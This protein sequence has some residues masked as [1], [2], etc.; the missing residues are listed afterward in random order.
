MTIR[1]LISI[2]LS[3]TF[4][5][6]LPCAAQWESPTT[7]VAPAPTPAPETEPAAVIT[8]PTDEPAAVISPPTDEPQAVI[9]PPT[10]NPPGVD[11][12]PGAISPPGTPSQTVTGGVKSSPPNASKGGAKAP[13]GPISKSISFIGSAYNGIKMVD[14]G[15][16]DR[17]SIIGKTVDWTFEGAVDTL[18]FTTL[19]T[20]KNAARGVFFVGDQAA[21]G[22]GGV[23]K[24]KKAKTPKT[25][26]L[27]KPPGDAPEKP[28][29]GEPAA[30][31]KLESHPTNTGAP[32]V[33][34]PADMP[35][36]DPS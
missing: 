21:K 24:T 5:L 6:P 20:G 25:K 23:V 27:Q 14:R 29:D 17:L 18:I 22:V 2:L 11:T 4:V 31:P 3:G 9:S 10:D 34:R 7:P 26:D 19:F 35:P 32:P 1:L 30:E 12:P 16:D 28:V 36:K 13:K 33:E 8:A 15:I